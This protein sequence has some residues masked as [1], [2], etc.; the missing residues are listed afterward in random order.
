MI[1]GVRGATTVEFN[2]AEQ[3]ITRSFELMTELV[4][5]NNISPEEVVSVY[6]SATEDIDAA[7]PAKSLRRLQGW[8]YVPVMCMREIN[9]P[10]SLSKCIRVMVTVETDIKQQDIV[11][12]YHYDAEKL[13][14][15][16]KSGKE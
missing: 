12:V 15:D 13:R 14:P 5:E 2:D 10:G 8:T 16:L 4:R 7:F 6:F 1:R 9:V 11:H 3:I